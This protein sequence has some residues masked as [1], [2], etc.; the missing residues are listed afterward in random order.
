MLFSW[1]LCTAKLIILLIGIFSSP[2]ECAAVV[3]ELKY[4][5]RPRSPSFTTPDAVIKTLAGLMSV[6]KV[7]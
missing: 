4:L 3:L 1:R 2:K 5:P 7:C 6:N